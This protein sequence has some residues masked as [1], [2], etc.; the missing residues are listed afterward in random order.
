MHGKSYLGADE[1]YNYTPCTG[2]IWDLNC[3]K[4]RTRQSVEKSTKG[5]KVGDPRK[6]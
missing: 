1:N 4:L 6:H 2:C 5:A 3:G